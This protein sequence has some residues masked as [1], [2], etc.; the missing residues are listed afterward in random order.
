MSLERVLEHEGWS[1]IHR[2]WFPE[3]PAVSGP[4]GEVPLTPAASRVALSRAPLLY[5]H[6]MRA[7]EAATTGADVCLAT[8]TASGKTLAF[9]IAALDVVSRDI[10]ARVAVLYPLKALAAQQEERW[11]EAVKHAAPLPVRVARIDGSVPVPKRG[12]LL[13]RAQIVILTPDIVHAWLLRNLA[14]PAVKTFVSKLKLVIVDEAHEYR[15]VF[16]SNSAFLF[17]RLA[18][19][20]ERLSGHGPKWFSASATISDPAEHMHKLTGVL[21]QVIGPDADGSPRH[22]MQALIVSPPPTSDSNTS[23]GNVLRQLGTGSDRFIAFVDSRRQVETLAAIAGRA[24]DHDDHES[25]SLPPTVLPYRSGYEES[26]RKLIQDRFL[27]GDLTGVVSTS[28]LELGIDIGDLDIGLQWGAPTSATA[29]TQRMGRVGRSRPGTFAVVLGSSAWDLHVAQNPEDLFN[30]PLEPTTVYLDNRRIQYIHAMC[31]A[32]IDG[33]ADALGGG[34]NWDPKDGTTAWPEGFPNLCRMERQG[35]IPQELQ[36]LRAESGGDP[37][38]TFPLRDVSATFSVMQKIGG[39]ST[40]MGTVSHAQLMREAYPGAVYWYMAQPFRVRYVDFTHRQV[41][42]SQEKHYYTK[43]IAPRPAIWPNLS[44]APLSAQRFD[45]LELLESSFTIS[46][47][48][49]GF[50]ERKGQSVTQFLYPNKHFRGPAMRRTLFS[51]GV[52][53]FHGCLGEADVAGQ[54]ADILLEAFLLEAPIERVDVAS[55]TNTIKR[56]PPALAGRRFIAIYD[57]TYG[58]LRLSSQLTQPATLRNC[59]RV[60]LKMSLNRED[61]LP[62]VS[63][64]LN[65]LLECAN[66]DPTPLSVGLNRGVLSG[67]ARL[68]ASVIVPGQKGLLITGGGSEFLVERVFYTPEGLTYKGRR[69]DDP[70]TEVDDFVPA[71]SVVPIPG[72]TEMGVY[73]SAT[74]DVIPESAYASTPGYG[75]AVPSLASMPRYD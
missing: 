26:D 75:M 57:Q 67:G 17:R 9:Q 29:L 36:S 44:V 24:P 2:H 54:V 60:A 62:Y 31:L 71:S 22:P 56:G 13:G 69:I 4:V 5:R 59:L 58:S 21:P 50:T 32:G 72:E 11:N 40:P 16:G 65:V 46:E 34:E 68:G 35:Q 10:A 30:R 41:N 52:C 43:P 74:G 25:G 49:R 23:L 6:Q 37:W 51:T 20:V 19:A 39:G 63:E 55:G 70:G 27:H 14:D 64:A 28:A 47:S 18:Y 61:A 48:V 8:R 66:T 12:A 7:I 42:V 73:N 33:E 45:A 38:H 1:I 15:G 53:L 3:E